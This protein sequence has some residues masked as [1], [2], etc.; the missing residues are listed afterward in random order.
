MK[1][2][3]GQRS[4]SR[5]ENDVICLVMFTAGVTVIKM[6]KMAHFL[7]FP[8]IAVVILIFLP[9][10]D[11]L[12][13]IKCQC[14]PHI[15]TSQ[16]ICCV[17]QLTGFCMRA[18]LALNGLTSKH[19]NHTIFWK[20]LNKIFQMQLYI[21]PKLV[22]IL[23]LFLAENTKMSHFWHFYDHNSAKKHDY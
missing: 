14:Y 8:L 11:Y 18:T 15:E 19:I 13:L 22:A 16:L 12:N 17:N 5:W 1:Y 21:S 9:S 6:S 20:K 3:N 2:T 23:F 10:K 7:Y 4:T